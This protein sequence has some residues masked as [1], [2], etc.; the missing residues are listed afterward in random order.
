M[1]ITELEKESQRGIR[2]QKLPLVLEIIPGQA[3][4]GLVCVYEPGNYESIPLRELCKNTLDRKNISIEEQVI[5]EDIMK[6]LNGGRLLLRGREIKG[7]A[8]DCAVLGET[9]AGEKYLYVP[10][11]A[12]RPQEGGCLRKT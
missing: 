7:T 6:Q 5:V 10:I 12:I 11:R 2:S 8:L 3:G 9:Q 1:S 4:E